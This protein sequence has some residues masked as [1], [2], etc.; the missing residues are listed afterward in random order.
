MPRGYSRE[1]T[2]VH[3]LH[4][5]FVWCPK[6]RKPVLTDEVADRLQQL[7]E[8]KADEFDLTILRLAIQPDHVHLFIT[9][10]PR[11]TR[12]VRSRAVSSATS[13]G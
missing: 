4:Y 12:V 10:N 3:N 1:R 6:Y 11:R 2:S 7:V 8:A 13:V 5:H 9:G